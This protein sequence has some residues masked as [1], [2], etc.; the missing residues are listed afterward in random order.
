MD[1][2]TWP[3]TR[4]L[5]VLAMFPGCS[6]ALSEWKVTDGTT[7]EATSSYR[8]VED[9]DNPLYAS[10]AGSLLITNPGLRFSASSPSTSAAYVTKGGKLELNGTSLSTAGDTAHGIYTDDAALDFNSGMLTT[11][12]D[13]AN[14]IM[15]R[16][17]Q[18]NLNDILLQTAGTS[19]NGIYMNG[20]KLNAK[21]V[22]FVSADSRS[23]GII[24]R[25]DASAEF[26]DVEI[27]MK[28]A[29][30][31]HSILI[32]NSSLNGNKVIID[33]EGIGKSAVRV[34]GDEN[35][36]STLAL[37]DSSISSVGIGIR[38]MSSDLDLNNVTVQTSGEHAYGVDI[39]NNSTAVIT[40]GN[41]KTSGQ[42]SHGLFVSH[43]DS[44]L[45][46]TGTDI[47]TT[48]D[49]AH[50]INAQHGVSTIKDATLTTRGLLSYG[51]YTEGQAEGNGLTISTS[52][53]K[54]YGVMAARGGKMQ[55]SNTTI[56]TAGQEAH[57]AAALAG[58]SLS[59]T[60][61]DIT[62]KGANG[63]AVIAQ[64]A[65]VGL[66][67]S[68]LTAAG[69]GSK[70]IFARG[71]VI[72]ADNLSLN[73]SGTDANGLVSTLSTFTVS[74][75]T[76]TVN[77]T[78][79]AILALGKAEGSANDLTL[80][81]TSVE[82]TGGAAIVAQATDLNLTLT[83]GS[84]LTNADGMALYAASEVND[85]N[86]PTFSQLAV[87]AAGNIRLTGDV[88]AENYD[89]TL[90]LSLANSSQLSGAA[91]N[92]NQLT[93]DKS[94]S[95]LLNDD[96]NVRTLQHD[97]RILFNNAKGFKTLTVDGDLSGEGQ[98]VMNTQLEGDNSLTDRVLVKGDA[99]GEF[100]L[101]INNVNGKGAKTDKG[102]LLVK[103]DGNSQQAK[104]KENNTVVAGNYQYFVNKKG[105]DAWYLEAS[106]EETPP[107]DEDKVIEED[108]INEEDII[109]DD[110]ITDG[111]N[112]KDNSGKDDGDNNGDNGGNGAITQPDK[113]KTWR[114][115]TAG[116]LITAYL[117][118]QYGFTSVG[119]YHQRTGAYQEGNAVWGKISDRYDRYDAGRF[120][121]DVNTSL[122]QI[123]GD[124]VRKDLAND[125][126]LTA[127]PSFSA[128]RQRSKNKDT[129]RQLRPGLSEQVGKNYTT[130]LGVGGYLTAWNDDGT[131]L[132]TVLQVTRYDN[133]L[134]SLNNAKINSYGTVLS[135]EVGKPF[136]LVNQLR[137][138]PQVQVM[139]QYLNVSQTETQGVKLKEQN[140][141]V[142]QARGG[143]RLYNEGQTVQ[144]YLQA[145][146]VQLLGDK[147]GVKMNDETL[148]PD[149][150]KAYWQAGMGMNA[151]FTPQLS[152]YAEASYAH[153]FGRGYEG[154]N[155]N[156]GV[157]YQF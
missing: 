70:G 9:L 62:L 21:A 139:G 101:T 102:I 124:L 7:L 52:G 74:N 126:H 131:Y 100:G 133:S 118:S 3:F 67:N 129:A 93:L 5:I 68:T 138:E 64:Q 85:Q 53:E 30:A 72:K 48:G 108:K 11:A 73:V 38:T 130:A 110:E 142:G 105:D 59:L 60:N 146:I 83:D 95:W 79:G 151:R 152:A 115:E 127:G 140:L 6:Y 40:Q 122:I 89:N 144:P 2:S 57:G 136:T 143:L 128:G 8:S 114:P 157:K 147:P 119:T 78:T 109:I 96:S 98:F 23:E 26:D 33:S 32:D 16:N 44:V 145:D 43:S 28:G 141:F 88:V 104:F 156:I 13:N 14:G 86:Q 66:Q 55:V 111:D 92:V 148:T 49:N 29:G 4:N 97:G 63:A 77:G 134:N 149:I 135:A 71:S 36:R 76:L 19:A 154:Y 22:Q 25:A 34:S 65:T 137:L 51:F 116:Y 90:N 153:N 50:A 41:Y 37:T 132:D 35:I 54:G 87:T 155:G 125:W 84:S 1:I 94:S 20:G 112:G 17:S 123:G 61:T 56:S 18:I 12:G 120:N 31:G 27:N 106:Y 117:N 150:E 10:G 99:Q 107:V 75:S 69:T 15:A 81:N 42:G 91:K 39:N 45:N 82:S 113:V 46:V 58:S 80:N 121:F 103:V 47:E 24:L